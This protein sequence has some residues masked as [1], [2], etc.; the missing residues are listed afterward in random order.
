M[1]VRDTEGCECRDLAHAR[2][3]AVAS[4]RDVIA[5]DVLTGALDLTGSIAIC[6]VADVMLASV[7]F[8]DAVTVVAD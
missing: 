8:R 4:I 6:D 2:T 1:V 5:A 7:S 3:V